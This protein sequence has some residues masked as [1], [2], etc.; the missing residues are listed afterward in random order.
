MN[1]VSRGDIVRLDSR[2]LLDGLADIPMCGETLLDIGTGPELPGIPLAIAQPDACVT[3]GAYGSA[4]TFLQM[5]V[6]AGS[7]KCSDSGM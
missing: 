1:L 4:R 6:R 5:A 2:P 3:V 7:A